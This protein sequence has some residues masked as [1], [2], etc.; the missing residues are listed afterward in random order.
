VYLDLEYRIRTDGEFRAELERR[1]KRL[2]ELDRLSQRNSALIG[3]FH[4]SLFDYLEFCQ[5]NLANLAPYFWPAYPKEQPLYFANYPFAYQ[6][7]CFQVGGF[8]V[9]RGSRQISKTT[10]FASRQS[11]MARLFR[12]FKSLYIVPRSDQLATYQNKFREIEQ[13]NR[14]HRRDTRL[15]QNLGYKELPNRSIIEMAR[16]QTT[17]AGIRGK[18]TDELLFDEFQHFDPELELEVSQ[19]Q[20]AS[21]L[22]ITIYAGTSLTT[23]S[24]LEQRWNE[25]SQG[26]WVMRCGCGHWSIPLPE[27]DVME[28]IR[29]E[30]PCCL[31]CGRLLAVREGKFVHAQQDR[32][33][34]GYRGFHIPQIIVPAVVYNPTRWAEIYWNKVRSGGGRKFVQ[35]ILGVATEQ[36]EKEITRTQLQDICVLGR[37]KQRLLQKA[38]Q[39]EY[40]YT[41]SG[42][43]WGGSDHLPELRIKR[44]TTVHVIAGILP[45]GQFEI[46][47]FR[48][49]EGMD[50]EDITADIL[51]HHA[52]YR[53]YALASDFGVG[54]VYNSALRR[55]IPVGRHLIFNYVGPASPLISQP[56]GPHQFNGWSLNKSESISL[57]YDAVRHKRIRCFDFDLAEPYLSDFLNLF[58]APGER[59]QG[60]G[61]STFLYRSHP[62]KPTDA[63]MAVNYAFMLGK[64]LLGEPMVADLSTKVMLDNA[65]LSGIGADQLSG[66]PGAFS[67]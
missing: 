62:T 4:Q 60:G 35:E 24:A 47:H 36:G 45:T 11:M 51:R 20:A 41:V 6:M 56:K 2:E 31:K 15:R 12:G 48:R 63:L 53:G 34:A 57:T 25:S 66:L 3:A 29:P 59:G 65:L 17:A 13:A 8:M 23:D 46:L 19:T 54:A 18:S 49:F 27:F 33:D 55:Q 28:M 32:F 39:G 50:Y 38:V 52:L 42:C 14:F 43:D 26:S 44:S 61:A 30:G 64:I 7:F 37:D 9:F 10:S 21:E 67:G 16:V 58:R 40:E 22:K 5:F 1:Q